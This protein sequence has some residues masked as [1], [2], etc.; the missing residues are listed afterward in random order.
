M[1]T[2]EQIEEIRQI[3][4]RKGHSNIFTRSKINQFLD[5]VQK[6]HELL[7]LYETEKHLAPHGVV[8]SK[9]IEEEVRLNARLKV[10]SSDIKLLKKEIEEMK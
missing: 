2:K 4:T 1:P 8:F 5:L 9:S 7:G 10:I 3:F 6:E